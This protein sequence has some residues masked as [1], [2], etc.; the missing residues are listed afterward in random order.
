MTV[1]LI[2]LIVSIVALATSIGSLWVNSLK[3][4]KLSVSHDAPTFKLYKITPAIS[5]S[6][7]GETWWIPSFDVGMSFYNLGRRPGEVLDVRIVAKLN[8]HR[9]H[10]KFV[11][12]PKWIVNYAHFQKDR[13]HRMTWLDSAVSRDWYPFMLGPMGEKDLHVIL[14]GDRWDHKETGAIELTF[15]VFSSAGEA[16]S[17]LGNYTLHIS[18]DMFEGHSSYTVSD[19]KIENLRRIEA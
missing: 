14:E 6:K 7:T 5:G 9:S 18:D 19:K 3:P 13:A 4:F 17:T 12:Y 16:W 10:R 11:F 2:A 8:G 1:P 15:A